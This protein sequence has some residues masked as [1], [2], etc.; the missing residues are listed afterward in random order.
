[1]QHDFSVAFNRRQR[2]RLS[3]AQ[4]G[5]WF[6]R[7]YAPEVT[8]INLGINEYKRHHSDKKRIAYYK[9]EMW[10]GFY[11]LRNEDLS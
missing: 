5:M 4:E 2:R 6:P 9:K 11:N 10:D 3:F 7:S 1:M 8:P